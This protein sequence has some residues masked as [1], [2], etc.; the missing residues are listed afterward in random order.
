M[1]RGAGRPMTIF[2]AFRVSATGG[3]SAGRLNVDRTVSSTMTY[4]R[5]NVIRI[6]AS[7]LASAATAMLGMLCTGCFHSWLN[8]WLDPT[9]VGAFDTVHTTEI[10]NSISILEEPDSIDSAAEP[11]LEDLVV[12]REEYRISEGDLVGIRIFELLLPQTETVLQS[13]VNAT[14]SIYI[15][16]LDW[17]QVTG[18]TAR[19]LQGLLIDEIQSRDILTD[20]NVEVNVP[21]RR[22]RVFHIYGLIGRAGTYAIPEPDFRLLEALLTAGGLTELADEVIIVRELEET[23]PP[24]DPDT[25]IPERAPDWPTTT[26]TTLEEFTLDDPEQPTTQGQ[27]Q[28][29]AGYQFANYTMSSFGQDPNTPSSAAS[30]VPQPGDDSQPQTAPAAASQ[31]AEPDVEQLDE[32]L[33]E[34]LRPTTTTTPTTSTSAP[35]SAPSSAPATAPATTSPA[36]AVAEP[37]GLL[38]PDAVAAAE[39]E[40]SREE[41]LPLSQWIWLNGKWIEVTSAPTSDAAAPDRAAP[42]TSGPTSARTQRV[43]DWEDLE[44]PLSN[45]IISIPTDRLR[46]GD[47]RFNIVV[48]DN[49]TIR[50][51]AGDTGNYYMMGHVVRPGVYALAGFNVT[52]KQAIASAGGMDPL[53]W[54]DRC[55]VVRR[56]GAD[57]E[58]IIP[59]D[60]DRIFSGRDPDFFVKPNDIVNV[61]THAI[62]PF[63]ATIRSAFRLTY[64]FGFVWDRNFGDIESQGGSPNPRLARAAASAATLPGLFP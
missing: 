27:E 10:R 7:F 34:A 28:N 49:D 39:P 17:I 24:I 5:N 56:I 36:E 52:V 50:V 11:T 20:P 40:L 47:P 8:D 62:A 51:S 35:S 42:I 63:L 14:G 26:S 4:N 46:D 43:V 12:R 19:E 60:L 1:A 15:P 18:M 45:R 25:S 33:L 61:G 54:P 48:R 38:E 21:G 9:E 3:R 57:R 32:D 30:D 58:T 64:G 13:V 2:P 44:V 29:P 41:R 16:E 31:A 6:R 23:P 22:Q 37:R 53:G 55:E 59:I